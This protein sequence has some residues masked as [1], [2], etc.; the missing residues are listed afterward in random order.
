[1]TDRIVFYQVVSD[2][3]PPLIV[4]RLELFLDFIAPDP[5]VKDLV[6]CHIPMSAVEEFV[7]GLAKHMSAGVAV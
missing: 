2:A 1:M 5:D 3:I 6:S 7:L 4:D